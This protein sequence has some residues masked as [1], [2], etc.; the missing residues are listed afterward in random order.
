MIEL[1]LFAWLC[2]AV[3][4]A[5]IVTTLCLRAGRRDRDRPN[6]DDGLDLAV[7]RATEFEIVEDDW[8]STLKGTHHE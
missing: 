6:D 4:A 2:I 5:S 8:F 7:V 1:A 3:V